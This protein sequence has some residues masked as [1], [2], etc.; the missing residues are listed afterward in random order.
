VGRK[1][2]KDKDKEGIAFVSNALSGD[3]RRYLALGGKGFII[4]DGA[5]NYGR[6]Q[7]L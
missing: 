3:H 6:E 2:D 5:L 7:I 1:K 4:G